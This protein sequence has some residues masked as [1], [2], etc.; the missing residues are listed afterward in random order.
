[1][2]GVGIDWA[3]IGAPPVPVV[4]A[5]TINE[6]KKIKLKRITRTRI[7]EVKNNFFMVSI[8]YSIGIL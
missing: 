5:N 4:S 6:L 8:L 7:V 3:G 2:G 1:M